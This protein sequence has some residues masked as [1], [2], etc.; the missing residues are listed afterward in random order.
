MVLNKKA[1][2]DTLPTWIVA[3]VVFLFFSLFFYF[4]PGFLMFG[5]MWGKDKLNGESGNIFYES[6]SKTLVVK[7]FVDFLNKEIEFNGEKILVKELINFDPK[8]DSKGFERF[9]ELSEEFL[10][11]ENLWN[12]I[13]KAWIKVYLMNETTKKF[14][15]PEGYENFDTHIT[16]SSDIASL[17]YFDSDVS[18]CDSSK[19]ILYFMLLED[20]K[21]ELCLE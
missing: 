19:G 5:E 17:G 1:S 15:R 18:Y 10:K 13:D 12:K 21:V 11:E 7:N 9:R 14:I 2:E 6:D 3:V 8:K 4:I 20:R 16:S